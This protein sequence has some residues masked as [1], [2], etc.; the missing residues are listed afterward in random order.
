MQ[1]FSSIHLRW[2]IKPQNLQNLWKFHIN[3][4]R[5]LIYVSRFI[6]NLPTSKPSWEGQGPT[7]SQKSS[8]C[9]RPGE[10][11]CAP[12]AILKEFFQGMK[13][14]GK[15][16]SHRE[17]WHFVFVWFVCFCSNDAVIFNS[18]KANKEVQF[19]KW[20]LVRKKELWVGNII[21]LFVSW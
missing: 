17:A 21:L 14:L 18:W 20:L 3:W 5:T 4:K 7:P 19:L 1:N 16:S 11:S 15:R 9:G 12:S 10:E 2:K 8:I 13:P 6:C